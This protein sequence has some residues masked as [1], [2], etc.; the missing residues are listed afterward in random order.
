MSLFHGPKTG[1]ICL[2]KGH[3]FPST[4]HKH[5]SLTRSNIASANKER[6]FHN[7]VSTDT[8]VY[9]LCRHC[10]CNVIILSRFLTSVR[11]QRAN[12]CC[13]GCCDWFFFTQSH[14]T[15]LFADFF[16][17]FNERNNVSTKLHSLVLIIKFSRTEIKAVDLGGFF[18][19]L[20]PNLKRL[21]YNGVEN[22]NY[23]FIRRT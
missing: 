4:K 9:H 11:R 20:I 14:V 8:V 16:F 1:W 19:V 2:H 15:P 6:L 22:A 3:L 7:M 10:V 12:G 17:T 23:T 5:T 18:E 13:F 21:S